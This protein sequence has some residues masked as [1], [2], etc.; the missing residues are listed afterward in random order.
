MR[1]QKEKAMMSGWGLEDLWIWIVFRPFLPG[2]ESLVGYGVRL[3]GTMLWMVC[4]LT[5]GSYAVLILH[6]IRR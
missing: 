6:G 2:L 3:L 1:N 5:K 4:L